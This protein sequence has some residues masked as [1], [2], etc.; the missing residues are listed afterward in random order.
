M[1]LESKTGLKCATISLKI[2]G[3]RVWGSSNINIYMCYHGSVPSP[4]SLLWPIPVHALIYTC[5]VRNT[6]MLITRNWFFDREIV[7]GARLKECG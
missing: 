5:K 1:S 6:C 7:Y 3:K 2:T 4:I